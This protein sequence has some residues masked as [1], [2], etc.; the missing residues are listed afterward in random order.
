MVLGIQ[1]SNKEHGL[2]I[3]GEKSPSPSGGFLLPSNSS[4]SCSYS[5]AGAPRLG[6]ERSRSRDASCGNGRFS[7]SVPVESINYELAKPRKV[8]A[9]VFLGGES[10][11][12][13]IRVE[14]RVALLRK[15]VLM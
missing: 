6:F 4:S 14:E 11:G 5:P 8:G 7:C 13:V 9:I 12:V 2:V 3:A 1:T 10:G 15:S